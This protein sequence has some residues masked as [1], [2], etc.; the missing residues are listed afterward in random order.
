MHLPCC[1]FWLNCGLG[2]A[3]APGHYLLGH[4]HR[5]LCI[6]E[7]A[8]VAVTWL[9]LLCAVDGERVDWGCWLCSR[10]P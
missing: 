10:L 8:A 1:G 7:A 9:Q 4:M 2:W 5:H 3:V 6:T